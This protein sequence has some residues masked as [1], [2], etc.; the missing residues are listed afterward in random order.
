MDVIEDVK[1][2]LTI[3]AGRP[4]DVAAIA[5][6]DAEIGGRERPE[7][8]QRRLAPYWDDGGA[9][10][11]V[12]LVAERGGEVAGFVLGEVRG[13]EFDLAPCGW[14]VTIGVR[15]AHRGFG[16]GQRLVAELVDGLLQQGISTVRTMVAW[17]NSELVSFFGALGFDCGPVLPLEKRIADSTP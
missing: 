12:C 5:A 11:R 7:F 4:D 8:W 2:A 14:I 15:P 3:R 10:T 13:D 6:I 16:V 1:G 9:P 17:H